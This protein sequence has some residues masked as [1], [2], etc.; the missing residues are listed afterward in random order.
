M[1]LDPLFYPLFVFLLFRELKKIADQT[2]PIKSWLL[3][4]LLK[5]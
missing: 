5:Q 3:V 1:G 4:H 2:S